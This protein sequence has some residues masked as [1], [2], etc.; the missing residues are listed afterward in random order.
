[1]Q[2]QNK[3]TSSSN[4]PGCPKHTNQVVKSQALPFCIDE[5]KQ[6][7]KKAIEVNKRASLSL[8]LC[9]SV[10]NSILRILYPTELTRFYKISFV[11]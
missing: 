11:S 3:H 1:M 7:C 10:I 9:V 2:I 5:K 4:P 8:N 6:K